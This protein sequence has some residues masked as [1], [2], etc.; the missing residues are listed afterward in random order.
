MHVLWQ[1]SAE[2]PHETEMLLQGIF[3]G[4]FRECWCISEAGFLN[5]YKSTVGNVCISV[6]PVDT[7]T[8]M[9]REVWHFCQLKRH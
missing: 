6:L 9:G 1:Y 5:F 4:T 3:A 2:Q 8:F 7:P